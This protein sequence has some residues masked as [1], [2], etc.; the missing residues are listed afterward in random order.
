MPSAFALHLTYPK[1]AQPVDSA[2]M[3]RLPETALSPECALLLSCLRWPV[4]QEVGGLIAARAR[5]RIDWALFLALLDRHRVAGIAAHGL[6]EA[7][8]TL[9]PREQ[10]L[11]HDAAASSAWSELMLAQELKCL[12]TELQVYGIRP[13]IL[14]GLGLSKRAFGRL[15]LRYN[16][17]IDLFVDP[18]KV[19]AA[20]A[21]LEARGYQRLE[22]GPRISAKE[23]QTWLRR[24]KDVVYFQPDRQQTVEVH[25]RLFDNPHLLPFAG[26]GPRAQVTLAPGLVVD[27][28]PADLDFI[29]NCLHSTQ[30]GWS[31][32][33]WLADLAALSAAMP[34]AQIAAIY[35]KARE[36]RVHRPVAQ[37]LLL[38]A[39]LFGQAIPASVTADA[40]SD[41]RIRSLDAVAHRALF[42]HGAVEIDDIPLG[43]TAINASHYLL[44]DSPRYWLNEMLF[45]LTDMTGDS[46]PS[47]AAV[48]RPFIRPVRWLA[49]RARLWSRAKREAKLN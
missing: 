12:H 19:T 9:P 16:R 10:A 42:S 14:K 29:Y 22:P 20:G 18:T 41:W 40:Y 46:Q 8:V 17:D 1:P 3:V 34:P 44:S 4:T 13:I 15:G 32:L 37:A 33:K 26:S 21:V 38:C 11:L 27:T 2:R 43:S 31:R 36:L 6:R 5:A 48:L 35:A 45:D 7:G 47:G 24:H 25:G 30:H 39:R 28:L 49:R 23:L